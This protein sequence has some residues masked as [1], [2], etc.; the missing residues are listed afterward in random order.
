M[1]TFI[2]FL[3]D[4]MKSQQVWLIQNSSIKQLQLLT[5]IIYN[6]VMDVFNLQPG[7]IKKLSKYKKAIRATL[8]KDLTHR[9]RRKRLTKVVNILPILIQHYQ[10]WQG[11]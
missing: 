3:K 9:Q 11:N 2:L 5:E 8:A 1:T 4:A 7:D 6:A 10:Q